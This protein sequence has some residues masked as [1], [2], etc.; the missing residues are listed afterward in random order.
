MSETA[1][2]SPTTP[3]DAPPAAPTA[4]DAPEPLSEPTAN[5]WLSSGRVLG[6]T[7]PAGRSGPV[8]RFTLPS[9]VDPLAAFGLTPLGGVSAAAGLYIDAIEDDHLIIGALYSREYQTD[10][11][12]M[13]T[14]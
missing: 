12:V 7:V 1:P 6:F 13:V 11:R 8:A 10:V 9:G 14:W 4:P 3:Q 2:E 5:E